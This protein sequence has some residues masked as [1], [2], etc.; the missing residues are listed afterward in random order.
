MR[1]FNTSGPNDPRV[2]YTLLREN[3]LEKG[4]T[5]VFKSR[6]F[7]IWAPRQTGKSTYF[8]LL[9]DKLV[10]EGYKVCWINFEH[11]S[12]QPLESFLNRL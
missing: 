2:H 8:L 5:K 4:L 7:T 6:Y 1:E 9:K 10:K 11:Y 12:K 3:L